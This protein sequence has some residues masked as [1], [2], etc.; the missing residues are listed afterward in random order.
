MLLLLL[1]L[2]LLLLLL[3]LG[4]QAAEES[5]ALLRLGGGSRAKQ[6]TRLLLLLRLRHGRSKQTSRLLW[7]RLPT[8]GCTWCGAEQTTGLGW[9]AGVGCTAK[10]TACSW[11][12]LTRGTAAENVCFISNRCST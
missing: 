6:P 11:R 8:L 5:A 3:W 1:W 12:L 9:L 10:E 4:S 7:L 2:L